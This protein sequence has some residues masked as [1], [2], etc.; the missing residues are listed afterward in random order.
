VKIK[1]KYKWYKNHNNPHFVEK[2][3]KYEEKKKK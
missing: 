2:N 1:N 3:E